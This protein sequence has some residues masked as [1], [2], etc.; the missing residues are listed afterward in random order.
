MTWPGQTKRVEGALYKLVT[1]KG[2]LRVVEEQRQGSEPRRFEVPAA[3]WDGVQDIDPLCPACAGSG[4]QDCSDPQCNDSTWD[5][6][7]T[8]GECDNCLGSGRIRPGA[9]RLCDVIYDRGVRRWHYVIRGTSLT[10]SGWVD[11][12]PTATDAELIAAIRE[13]EFAFEGPIRR[14]FQERA[15]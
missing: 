9:E 11:A 5:H 14:P 8:A 7:C 2:D 6:D 10:S 3:L 15:S 12:S 1:R 4:T 13:F